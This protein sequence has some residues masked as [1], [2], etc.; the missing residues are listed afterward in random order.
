M[1]YIVAS[2]QKLERVCNG[3]HLF[4]LYGLS[5]T[6][7]QHNVTRYG[8]VIMILGP[9]QYHELRL[10]RKL[11]R[12]KKSKLKVKRLGRYNSWGASIWWASV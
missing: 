3:G 11:A 6:E 7:L 5:E 10:L 9:D 2:F 4:A 8:R 1:R 12:R